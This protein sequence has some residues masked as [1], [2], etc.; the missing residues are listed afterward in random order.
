MCEREIEI[1][2][3]ERERGGII[4]ELLYLFKNFLPFK[5]IFFFKDG[6]VIFWNVPELERNNVIRFLGKFSVEGYEDDLVYEESEMMHY[7]VSDVKSAS[8]LDGMVYLNPESQNCDL[9]KYTVS[10]AIA[11]SVKLGIWEAS[12]GINLLLLKHMYCFI[13]HSSAD[14]LHHT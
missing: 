2:V 6:N 14:E 4:S 12:L 3:R 11:S 5:E 13:I 1:E 8:L 7:A 9:A 10:D